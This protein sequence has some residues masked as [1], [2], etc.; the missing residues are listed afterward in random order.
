MQNATKALIIASA[1]LITILIISLGLFIYS[2]SNS[3]DQ[4]SSTLGEMEVMSFN[5]QYRPYEG[6]RSGGEVKALL[7]KASQHNQ[8]LYQSQDIIKYCVCIRSNVQDILNYFSKDAQM[9]TGLNG[10]RS[11]GVRYHS[12]IAQISEGGSQTKKYKVWFSYNDYGYIWE[13]HVDNV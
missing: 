5:E 6:T 7:Q 1:V 11:Y 3:A 10:S 13:I 8:E 4:A 2:K 9:L 12:N